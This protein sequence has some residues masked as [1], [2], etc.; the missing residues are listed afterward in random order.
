MTKPVRRPGSPFYYARRA[1]PKALRELF[2]REQIWKSLGVTD[3]DE[4]KPLAHRLREGRRQLREKH[5][6]SYRELYRT[7]ELPGAHPMKDFQSALDDAVRQA[8]GLT[9]KGSA[10]PFLLKLNREVVSL[11]AKGK[12][13]QG[14]GLPK[15][16]KN[17]AQFVSADCITP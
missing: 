11:E 17:P 4:A 10:L 13:V 16:I 14:P 8:Y 5:G 7:L 15:S 2:G 6:L 3:C 9:K 1:I 12:A